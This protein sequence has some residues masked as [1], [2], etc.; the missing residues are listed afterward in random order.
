MTDGVFP[1]F[2]VTPIPSRAPLMKLIPTLA[3]TALALLSAACSPPA[4]QQ[5]PATDTDST[6]HRDT[7]ALVV[8]LCPT[9]GSLPLYY[10]AD[11]GLFSQNGVAVELKEYLSQADCDTAFLNKSADG[12]LTDLVSVS[13]HNR[14][15]A[16]LEVVSGT[17]GEWTLLT[18]AGLRIKDIR[19]IKRHSVAWTRFT[20]PHYLM[21]SAL[22]AAG[23][24]L[25][26]VFPVQINDLELRTRML[27]NN[28]I[29]AA[30]LPEPFAAT[31][32]SRGHRAVSLGTKP[33]AL[34]CIAFRREATTNDRK[35]K[36]IA[37]LLKAYD[38][39]VDSINAQGKKRIAPIITRH[40]R[41]DAAAF[42]SLKL[43][44]YRHAAVPEQQDYAL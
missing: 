11:K 37:L 13:H 33:P 20:A 4:T 2:Y 21:V 6:Q 17:D 35:K 30:L 19:Q 40:F 10:A 32:R 16:Q 8:A 24:D 7:T 14:H 3:A 44:R 41:L 43:P 29:D 15:G 27:N 42:D 34:G 39:A 12:G 23:I 18:G 36:Q 5:P 31:A 25:A 9:A 26:E 28:Q 38:Q 22:K 1:L